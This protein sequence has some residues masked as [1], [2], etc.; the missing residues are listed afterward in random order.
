M[1]LLKY[2]ARK[3]SLVASISAQHGLM[4]CTVRELYGSFQKRSEVP[5]C[6][7]DCPIRGGPANFKPGPQFAQQVHYMSL[8]GSLVPQWW[9]SLL[10]QGPC[11][12][13][14]TSAKVSPVQ[15]R[16]CNMRPLQGKIFQSC[17]NELLNILAA[18]SE[19]SQTPVF[20]E[21]HVWY[22]S[23]EK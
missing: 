8:Q 6:F 10:H 11:K 23:C 1:V 22:N 17:S 21:W 5:P 18:I 2:W 14:L 19:I 13:C 3:P 16:L 20:P 12:R 9:A 4:W 7:D 15:M